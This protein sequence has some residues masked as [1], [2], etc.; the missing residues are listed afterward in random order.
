MGS[1][2]LFQEI[3]SKSLTIDEIVPKWAAKISTIWEEGF[4]IPLSLQWWRCYFSLDSPA[5]CI[6]G[7]AHGYSSHYENECSICDS[8]GWD[9]GHSFLMRSNNDFMANVEKFVD[10][11]NEIHIPYER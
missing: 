9:F 2:I 6:I 3:K 5:K 7:E 11:W 8:I 4:P 1:M 10:H